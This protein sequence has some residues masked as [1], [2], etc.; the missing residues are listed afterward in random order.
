MGVLLPAGK[1]GNSQVI[2]EQPCS[3]RNRS[4]FSS[5]VSPGDVTGSD[6][7][8]TWRGSVWLLGASFPAVDAMASYCLSRCSRL[9]SN[10]LLEAVPDSAFL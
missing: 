1:D 6:D 10:A 7:A 3:L 8:F 4:I 9:S 5:N 2:L